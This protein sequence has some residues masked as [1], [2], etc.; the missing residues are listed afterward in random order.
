M[1]LTE[2][3]SQL[4]GPDGGLESKYPGLTFDRVIALLVDKTRAVGN[5]SG[6][7]ERDHYFGQLFGIECFVRSGV[8]FSDAERWNLILDLLLKLGNK[9]I[10][11]R[12]QCGWILA[13][14]LGRMGQ[15]GAKAT[16]LKVADAGLAKTPE[17]VAAWLI[18]QDRHPGLKVKPWRDPLSSKSLDDLAAVLR[19]SFKN[20]SKEGEE[21]FQENSKQAGWS[22]Q[23]HFVWD[24]ILACFVRGEAG[25]DAAGLSQFWNRVVDDGLFSR[26]ATDG[27]KFKGF[28]V[29]SKMLQGLVDQHAKLRCLFSK[30]LM[31]CLINQAAKEDRFL[32][33]AATKALRALEDVVSEHSDALVPV[34]DNLL[35]K[36]G[37]Y[38][39]DQ[40]TSTKTVTKLLQN[41]NRRNAEGTLA[42]IKRPL[43]SLAQHGDGAASFF[44]LYADYLAKILNAFASDSP[45]ESASDGE[46]GATYGPLLQELADLAYLQPAGIPQAA[47]TEPFREFCRSRLES[48]IARLARQNSDAFCNA[49]ASIDMARRTMSEEIK[50]AAEKALARLETLSK[51]KSKREDEKR[52]AQGLATLYAVSIFQL[53]N[54]HPDAM[55]VLDDV[56]QLHERFETGSGGD[57]S[58]ESS[59]LLIEILLAIVA[60]PSSLMRQVSQQV[61]D[62]FTSHIS[63]QGLALLIEPLAASESS[64]GERELF[65]PEDDGMD[66]DA[67]DS[68][69]SED[70]AD[71]T[72]E[73]D[74]EV[75][76]TGLGGDDTDDNEN[77]E[78][79]SAGS[80]IAIG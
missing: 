51:H 23:L 32:H 12:P 47:L 18:A 71:S 17:G 58:E 33:R 50:S 79:S 57:S 6:Q 77:E 27:Q 31:A 4:Y 72:V 21:K 65:N 45:P 75:E 44:R 3:L 76:F 28:L 74:A 37:A 78:D 13:E 67:G 70:D 63:A 24:T 73:I 1:V 9:K 5:I 62:A 52:L 15:D 53:Y 38:N 56:T 36:N 25:A 80:S 19:E 10:W 64:K 26:N 61:F 55:E 35:G 20:P 2:I 40:R 43:T 22:S 54:E 69:D 14:A 60:R 11:L 41:V 59:A 39:F 8:L 68:G 7:E 46:P 66:V 34:L 29:F 30:N 48:S 42:I 16:L 49:I